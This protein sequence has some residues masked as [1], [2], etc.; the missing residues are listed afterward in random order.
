VVADVRSPLS[1]LGQNF[2][3]VMASVA[4][5]R[6]LDADTRGV[7]TEVGYVVRDGGLLLFHVN[8]L[9]QA[10]C[11]CASHSDNSPM[12]YCCVIAHHSSASRK[13]LPNPS[14]AD[15]ALCAPCLP[16]RSAGAARVA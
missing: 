13:G 14:P 4:L 5:H 11:G 10:A 2:D 3:A 15:L 16:R 9:A 6:F 1:W 8:A 12:T 7:F